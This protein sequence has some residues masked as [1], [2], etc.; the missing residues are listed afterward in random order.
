MMMHLNP[1][2]EVIKPLKRERNLSM[3]ETTQFIVVLLRDQKD[4]KAL[5]L[6]WTRRTK[7]I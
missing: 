5:D 4:F 3:Q 7:S 6:I 2:L 1:D